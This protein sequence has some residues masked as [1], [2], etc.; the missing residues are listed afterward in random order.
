MATFFL[1]RSVAHTGLGRSL[2]LSAAFAAFSASRRAAASRSRRAASSFSFWT[3]L[4]RRRVPTG[5]KSDW[6][7]GRYA[8]SLCTFGR[9]GLGLP[10]TDVMA[11][12]PGAQCSC[13]TTGGAGVLLGSAIIDARRVRTTVLVALALAAADDFRVRLSG[14]AT[15]AEEL[16]VSGNAGR[17]PGGVDF[18]RTG[19]REG[20]FGAPPPPP[21]EVV[22]LALRRS[23]P[24]EPVVKMLF[25]SPV[26]VRDVPVIFPAGRVS[27]WIA[28]VDI[29]CGASG[30]S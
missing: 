30:A 16:S 7:R 23:S 1:S 3:T 9:F 13:V 15:L 5:W 21:L 25:S 20:L 27:V 8:A 22:P 10:A 17:P 2:S 14:G 6:A 11:S 29:S 12:L 4:G 26:L 18:E 24:V 19:T 28:V